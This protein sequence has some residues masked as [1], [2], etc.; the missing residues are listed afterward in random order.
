MNKRKR[1]DALG[2]MVL[3]LLGTR[4]LKNEKPVV[5]T[6]EKSK[7]KL[8]F[9]QKGDVHNYIGILAVSGISDI[10]YD[11][12]TL[13]LVDGEENCV[14][15]SKYIN[16]EEREEGSYTFVTDGKTK[17]LQVVLVT[18]DDT[19]TEES[20]SCNLTVYKNNQDIFNQDFEVIHGSGTSP[21]AHVF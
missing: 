19:L 8:V 3:G 10:D 1:E 15:R 2:L 14:G 6:T 11:V 20:V 12:D 13:E 21:M 4:S 9:T 18:S 17:S 16:M 5:K 7:F